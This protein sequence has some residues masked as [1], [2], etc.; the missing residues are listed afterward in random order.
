MS[1]KKVNE[2]SAYLRPELW[3]YS[4]AAEQGFTVSDELGYPGENPD[5]NDFGEF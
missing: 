2:A 4:V 3:L 5:F 1:M